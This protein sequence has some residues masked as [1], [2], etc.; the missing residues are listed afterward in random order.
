[1]HGLD[2][3]VQKCLKHGANVLLMTLLEVA[4]PQ[5]QVEQ[6]RQKLN[7]MIKDYVVQR[8]WDKQEAASNSSTQQP[9]AAAAAG[10]AKRS[11][12][13]AVRRT[14][15]QVH[16]FDLSKALP[17]EALDQQQQWDFWD[18]GVHLTM[19]GYDHMGG[20]IAEA[21]LPLMQQEL[22]HMQ[23]AVGTDKTAHAAGTAAAAAAAA[24][25]KKA[26]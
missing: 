3:L 5:E 13:S 15:P 19:A 10:G 14:K 6:Q 21:L 22:E 17:Y 20:L 8:N 25:G 11:D 12:G 7:S 24:E 4:M 16:L 1:M 18:D 26:K 9:G 23:A 2:V